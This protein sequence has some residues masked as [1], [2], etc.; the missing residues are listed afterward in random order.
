MSRIL[1]AWELGGNLGHIMR[2]RTVARALR[3]RGHD[4][5]LHK[6]PSPRSSAPDLPREPASY[7]E[8][9]LHYG[10]ADPA[11]LTDAVRRWR[12]LYAQAAPDL[13][14][15]DHAPTALLAAR[16]LGIPRVVLGT[17]FA[18][19][20]RVT[21]MPTIRPWQQIPVERLIA[22][23]QRALD[24]ANAALRA[25]GTQP[26]DVFHELLD[27][28]ENILATLPELDHYGARPRTKYW[29][30]I[31][32]DSNGIEPPW[33]DGEAK[34]LFVYIRPASTAFRPL[35]ALLQRA[36]LR[37]VWFAPGI[38]PDAIS[39]L[40]SP[41]LRIVRE[42]INVPLAV[43]SSHAAVLHGGHS[44]TAA[45]L[46]AGVP[47]LVLPE[48]VEQYLIGRNV[49]ALGAGAVVNVAS[50]DAP[51]PATLDRVIRDARYNTGARIFSDTYGKM[52]LQRVLAEV[53][54]QIERYRL[55]PL[56]RVTET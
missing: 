47:V 41:S 36:R 32:G 54:A 16:G 52:N 15:F 26:L 20:P 22:S 48:H 7:P 39:Q 11:A 49:A 56:E 24:T 17:G 43:R 10:F 30:P 45:M 37:T 9:L 21:P 2:M 13:I 33:P 28:E 29:G 12:S 31:S 4:V 34:K 23:E 5:S 19:P 38:R 27:V 53:V 14:V 25:L 46:L 42:P 51:L 8:I 55:R 6:E 35:V 40:E 50:P 44:T 3:E 18:S 1:F